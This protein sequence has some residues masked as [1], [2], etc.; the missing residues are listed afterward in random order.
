[1]STYTYLENMTFNKILEKEQVLKED[2]LCH[3]NIN[4]H[5]NPISNKFCYK[6]YD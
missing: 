5:Q 4:I 3:F 6:N 1:M 2:F